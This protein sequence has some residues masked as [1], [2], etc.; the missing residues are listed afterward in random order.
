MLYCFIVKTIPFAFS[1]HVSFYCLSTMSR[2]TLTNSSW[3]EKT[4]VRI[5]SVEKDIAV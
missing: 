1:Q 3:R 4:P 5:L 2:I